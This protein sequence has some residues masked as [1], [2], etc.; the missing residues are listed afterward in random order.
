MLD[1]DEIGDNETWTLI[2]SDSIVSDITFDDLQ[3]MY[4]S[5]GNL[6]R[7]KAAVVAQTTITGDQGLILNVKALKQSE[8]YR[9]AVPEPSTWLMM[10]LGVFGVGYMARRR[11]AKK[12]A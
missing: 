12:A 4:V 9:T 3:V 8:G 10:V 11:S 2:H 7:A 5:H 1:L 6:F